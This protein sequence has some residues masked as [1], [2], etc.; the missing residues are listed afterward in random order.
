MAEL[1]H[2]SDRENNF[3]LVVPDEEVN[4]YPFWK[5]RKQS[6][7]ERQFTQSLFEQSFKQLARA[8]NRFEKTLYKNEIVIQVFAAHCFGVSIPTRVKHLALYGKGRTKKKNINRINS[9]VKRAKK[10]N[11]KEMQNNED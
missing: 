2:V 1:Y 8:A 4:D 5:P 11:I 3:P 10:I 7:Q 6:Q 9:Y